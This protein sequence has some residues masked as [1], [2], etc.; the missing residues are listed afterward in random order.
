M[1]GTADFTATTGTTVVLAS[2]ATTGDLIRTE[3]F[4]V[5]SV[6]NAIQQYNGSSTNQTLTSPT[7]TSPALGTPASGVMTNVT[8]VPAAQLTGSQAVPKATLP[9]GSILQVLQASMNTQQTISVNTYTAITG[10]SQTITP[11]S[12]TSK[13]LIRFYVLCYL[14]AAN[15][16]GGC[17]IY[18]NGSLLFNPNIADATGPYTLYVS[19]G[20]G[21]IY[22]YEYLDSPATTS[23]TTYSIWARPYSTSYANLYINGSTGVPTPGTSVITLMEIAA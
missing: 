3:S 23:A 6:L 18:K 10:L 8:S 20:T 22:S 12:S 16:G 4:Y 9:T 11:T 14:S 13:V 19:G 1:L 7:M 15:A 17:A 2:G 21:A 5:S